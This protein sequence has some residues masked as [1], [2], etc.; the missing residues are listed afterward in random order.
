[1]IESPELIILFRLLTAHLIADFLLQ[2][3]GWIQNKSEG[4]RSRALYYHIAVVGILTWLFLWDP[5]EIVVPAIVMVTHFFIDWWKSSKKSTVG[6]FLADQAA[7]MTVIILVWILYTGMAGETANWIRQLFSSI[8]FWIVLVSY[9]L[10]SWPSGYLVAEM[11]KKWQDEI[12]PDG[13]RESTGL[14]NAGLW[15]GLSERFI[16]LTFILLNQYGAI[17]FLIAAKS[18]FRFSGRMEGDRDRKETEYILIGTLISFILS[19]ITGS[20]ALALLS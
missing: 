12:I 7:H 9:L 13:A 14:K 1:M 11:T 4:I 6:T 18:V 19:I 3:F 15:I 5:T 16:I 2:P 8:N 10:V 17:G 20:A